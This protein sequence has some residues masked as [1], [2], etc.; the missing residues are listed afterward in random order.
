MSYYNEVHRLTGSN[1]FKIQSHVLSKYAECGS[2]DAACRN[3]GVRLFHEFEEGYCSSRR[4][5]NV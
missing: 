5:V 2:V 3:N 1:D 4:S